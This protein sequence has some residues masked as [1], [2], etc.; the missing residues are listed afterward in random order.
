[1]YLFKEIIELSLFN[2][3]LMGYPNEIKI[4]SNKYID[5]VSIYQIVICYS[6]HYQIDMR[7]YVCDHQKENMQ[8]FFKHFNHIMLKDAKRF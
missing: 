3:R 6:S 7:D 8:R 1:M 5:H 2:S 4:T